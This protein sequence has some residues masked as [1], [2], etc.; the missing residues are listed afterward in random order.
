MWCNGHHFQKRPIWPLTE[1]WHTSKQ[2]PRKDG[3]KIALVEGH[4]TRLRRASCQCAVSP[5]NRLLHSQSQQT[6][7]TVSRSRCVSASAWM[8]T[9]SSRLFYALIA[10]CHDKTT[11]TSTQ[12]PQVIVPLFCTSN[13]HGMEPVQLSG[14]LV[15]SAYVLWGWGPVLRTLRLILES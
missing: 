3:E 8:W 2:L 11:R 7:D 6:R 14:P 5:P 4:P 13:P 1:T 15:E 10:S 12:P 9:A